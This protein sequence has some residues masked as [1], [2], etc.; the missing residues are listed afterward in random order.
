MADPKVPFTRRPEALPRS[1]QA[2]DELTALAW[3]AGRTVSTAP[4]TTAARST[5]FLFK[6]NF[7]W[8]MAAI[9]TRSLIS[10]AR[11]SPRRLTISH[12]CPAVVPSAPVSRQASS[13]AFAGRLK[14]DRRGQKRAAGRH[15]KGPGPRSMYTCTTLSAVPQANKSAI[16]CPS[17]EWHGACGGV[18]KSG[19]DS[20]PE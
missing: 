16:S 20:V 9:S 17:G 18:G 6:D 13:A 10:R 5:L 3:T 2:D 11:Y 8:L 7:P 12:A 15:R 1:G 19:P 14:I 4:S